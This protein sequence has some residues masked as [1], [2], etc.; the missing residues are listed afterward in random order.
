MTSIWKTMLQAQEQHFDEYNL[1]EANIMNQHVAP[2][3]LNLNTREHQAR[4]RAYCWWIVEE[5]SEAIEAKE[6]GS[7]KFFE[8]LIDAWHFVLE[9]WLQL[10][11]GAHE[12]SVA[13]EVVKRQQNHELSGV[14]TYNLIYDT[15]LAL[16]LAC[17][18]LK[19]KPWKKT[20]E[21][22]NTGL[23]MAH[24]DKAVRSFLSVLYSVGLDDQAI[25]NEYFN[26][27]EVNHA[28][29]QTGY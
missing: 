9:L 23:F 15:V 10:G 18:Q 2:K 14:M 24:A 5:L 12:L 11:L 26:K 13:A 27:S 1:I 29:K 8:E 25:E 22:T 20:F 3:V 19:L 6:L 21:P 28:R 17:N 4:V 16:G 7:D